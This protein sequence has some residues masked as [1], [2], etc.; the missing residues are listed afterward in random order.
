MGGS[1]QVGFGVCRSRAPTKSH[2]KFSYTISSVRF[3]CLIKEIIYTKDC[4]TGDSLNI[5]A[6]FKKFDMI[7]NQFYWLV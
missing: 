1:M 6:L 4:I 5:S 2:V 3:L 7:L